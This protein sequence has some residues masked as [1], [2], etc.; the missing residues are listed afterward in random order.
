MT[1][2][3]D[4]L[5]ST[6]D[7]MGKEKFLKVGYLQIEPKGKY[8]WKQADKDLAKVCNTYPSC[9]ISDTKVYRQYDPTGTTQHY[10]ETINIGIQCYIEDVL[11]SLGYERIQEM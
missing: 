6:K 3:F 11:K 7:K 10:A 8:S 9:Y 1:K 5:F 4:M 2:E